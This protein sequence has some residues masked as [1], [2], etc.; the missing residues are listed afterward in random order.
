MAVKLLM[1]GEAMYSCP[2]ISMLTPTLSL[3]PHSLPPAVSLR[4][5][6]KMHNPQIT[7][8]SAP[9]G[10]GQ[11]SQTQPINR[12]MGWGMSG[13]VQGLEKIQMPSSWEF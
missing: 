6:G 3:C 5:Q 2:V 7:N 13:G 10:Q 1:N 12:V 8:S 4:F 11:L 9:Y